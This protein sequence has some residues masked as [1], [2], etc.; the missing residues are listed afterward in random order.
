MPLKSRIR[1]ERYL[2]RTFHRPHD[3]TSSEQGRTASWRSRAD[4]DRLVNPPTRGDTES[5]LRWTCK[6]V[7]VL[8]E[9]LR[10]EGHAVSH[11]TVAELFHEMDYRL[12]ANQKKLAGSRHAD[13]N[14]Q[15]EYIKS[16]APN[17]DKTLWICPLDSVFARQK[18]S[19]DDLVRTALCTVLQ[20]LNLTSRRQRTRRV[21][22][23]RFGAGAAKLRM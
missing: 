11:Q 9:E 6:S 20:D 3:Q 12:Q 7:R 8:A 22:P 15:F 5:P 19:A 17:F 21:A 13:R 14:R 2:L 10:R 23:G 16:F 4:L 1:C 18:F